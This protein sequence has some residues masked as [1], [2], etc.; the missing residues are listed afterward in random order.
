MVDLKHK[1][2]YIFAA[3]ETLFGD[4][5]YPYGV[6]VDKDFWSLY[7]QRINNKFLISF[8]EIYED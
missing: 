2:S 6:E 8:G 1:S 4:G 7:M 5:Y 3:A